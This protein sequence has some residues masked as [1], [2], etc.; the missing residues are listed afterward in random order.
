MT[1]IEIKN[2]SILF[3]PEKMR[4]KR[5]LVAGKS[6][7]DILKET[8]CTVA[9]RNAN[10]K[11]EEGELFVIMGL[12]GSGKSTLLRCINRLNEPSLG[13][14][15]INGKNI[16]TSSDKELLDIRR[17]EMAMVFQHFGLLPHRTVLSNIAFGL[18]L[19]G[20]PKKERD[21]K[22]VESV[23]LVG[24]KGYE[25]QKVSELSGG[26]Q[27][28]VGLAR[29]IANDP[30]VLLMDEAFSAL[31]PLIRVQMQDELL[32]LQEKMQKTIIFITHDLDEAIKLGDRI[33]IMKDGEVVQVGTPEEILTDP[34][35]HY[36]SRFTENVDR[37]RIV[38]AS[39]IM[40]TQPVVA[41]IRK[42]G[43][44]TVLRKMKEKNL[45]VL[46]VVDGNRQ[47][48]GEVRLKDVLAL[49]KA[50]NHDLFH[51]AFRQGERAVQPLVLVL[52]QQAA[53]MAFIQQHVDFL[54]GVD[55]LVAA[56]R[57]SEELEQQQAAPVQEVNEPRKESERPAHGVI[58]VQ[59]RLPRKLESQR[60]GHQFPQNHLEHCQPHQNDQG[61]NGGGHH[62][63]H[64]AEPFKQRKQ[65]GRQLHLPVRTQNQAGNGNAELAGRDVAVK[66]AGVLQDFQQMNGHLAAALRHFTDHVAAHAHGGELCGNVKGVDQNQKENNENDEKNHEFLG[67][68]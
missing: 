12:S 59:G 11:I 34:A 27:Q 55:V 17:K 58:R 33:A 68:P 64:S 36:V 29:A 6:K 44:E 23:A 16:T 57:Q 45:Y 43:P 65:V 39:S 10:L 18:E 38:T 3:G 25:N 66:L 62:G 26:M 60:L 51:G 49:R 46:P 30:E 47:F 14:I 19:Q 31:D 4:A 8:G 61:G 40:I 35:N 13:E 5:M 15:F 24:L 7:Q 21:Q 20:V 48:L 28:R 2:L 63:V 22:A 41:R 56:R 54:L 1:K 37:G 9:V 42:D 50:G 52:F 32:K 53:L 67:C